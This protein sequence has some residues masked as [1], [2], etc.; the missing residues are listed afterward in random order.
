MKIPLACLGRLMGGLALSSSTLLPAQHNPA[1]ALVRH[2]LIMNA[3]SV[4]GSVQQVTAESVTLNGRASV[5]GD[6]LVPGT[7]AVRHNGRPNYGG[8]V[9]GAGALAPSNYEITL[10]GNAA[11]RHVV[12]R[13]DPV[14][15]PVVS[16]P[17]LPAGNRS[18]TINSAGQSIDDWKTVRNLTLNSRAGQRAVP[19]GTYGDFTANG[20]S[21]FTLG[22]ADGTVPS[23]Y[24]FQHLT[25]NGQA[26]FHVVG[27]VI[28]NLANGFAVNGAMGSPAHAAWLALNVHSGAI[29]L[30]NG[31]NLCGYFTAPGSAVT[32]NGNS[33]LIGGLVCDRLTI[34]GNGRLRLIAPSGINRPP[35]VAFTAP[36]DG[37]IYP[38]PASLTLLA[39]A[40][41]PDGTVARVEFYQ[42]AAKLGEC[43]TFPYQLALGSLAAGSYTFTARAFDSIG[44][45]ADSTPVAITVTSP[46]LPP[47]VSL[48]AP[49]DETIYTAPATIALSATAVDAD[50]TIG[51]VEFFNGTTKLGD[52]TTAPYDFAWSNVPPGHYTLTAKASDN[53][54][55]STVSAAHVI[56]VRVGWPY[57]TDFEEADGYTLGALAGQAGWEAGSGVIVTDGFSHQGMQSVQ[58]AASQP[59][60]EATHTFP[61]YTGQSVVFVDCHARLAAGAD[62]ESSIFTHAEIARVSL[63][64]SGTQG[65]LQVFNGNGVGGGVWQPTGF[66]MALTPEGGSTDWRRLTLREDFAAKRWDLYVDG[67][68]VACDVGF[69]DNS[70]GLFAQCALRGHPTVATVVDSFYAGFANPLV[71]DADQDGMDDAW[72]AAHG[73]NPAVDDRSGDLDGDSLANIQEVILGLQPDKASTYDDGIFDA[74]RVRLNLSLIGSTYD[75]NPPTAPTSLAATTTT[76]SVTLTWMASTDNLGV[77]GYMV[78]RGGQ[79]INTPAPIRS[80]TVTDEPLPNGETFSYQVRAFD[81][82]GNLSAFGETVKATTVP[83]DTDGSGMPDA[84]QWRYFGKIGID[85]VADADGDGLPN[86]LEFQQNTDPND[87]YNGVTPQVTSLVPPDGSLGPND[88][89]SVRLTS[90]DGRILANA[91]LTF[92]AKVGGHLLT[93]EPGGARQTDVTVRTGAN[94]VATVYVVCGGGN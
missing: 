77:A 74:D 52:A 61:A 13:T 8:T 88:S 10:N 44:A 20:D 68:L 53:M 38:A 9:D 84:W 70:K 28:V 21:G 79:A 73:L 15:L 85:P 64:Q 65:E 36:T 26:R 50:G 41:D 17:P 69:T 49:A 42:D 90:A 56:T 12:R 11:L 23:V 67:R 43:A 94:G 5:T 47:T 46:N 35:T 87:Y 19:P 1:T 71:T 76:T 37:A 14:G 82:A 51:K 32:L 60:A 62:A 57:F 78:Y 45:W 3:G 29:V 54:G 18:I 2:A 80:T 31:S 89:I 22:A 39:V 81:F 83:Q 24:N 58:L 40:I 75:T 34:N 72:E 33:Q 7:P 92:H 63:V 27:P 30:S 48:T 6:L 4:D 55:A 86:L 59:P 25:L 91:P 66:K 93:A 16:A